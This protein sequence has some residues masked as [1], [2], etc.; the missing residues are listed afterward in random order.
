MGERIYFRES[1]FTEYLEYALFDTLIFRSVLRLTERIHNSS[2]GGSAGG[3]TV[4]DLSEQRNIK[5]GR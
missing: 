2:G 1:Q 5:D 3:I 4:S